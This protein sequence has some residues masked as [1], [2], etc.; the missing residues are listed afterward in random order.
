V[1]H[2]AEDRQHLSSGEVHVWTARTTDDGGTT[3]EMLQF[4]DREE[5]AR[6][7]RFVIRAD[8]M[9]FIQSHAVA[10]QILAGYS[11]IDAA[12]L[13]FAHNERGKPYLASHVSGRSLQFSVSHSGHC[14]MIAV[15]HDH[16]V[17][18][19]VELVRDMPHAIDIARRYFAQAEAGYLNSL[20]E[21]SRQDAF[22]SLWT[23]KEAMVKA[24]GGSIAESL[25]SIEFGA[26]PGRRLRLRSINENPSLVRKWSV[27]RLDPAPG[28]VGAVASVRP[29]R[30]FKMRA[31]N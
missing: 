13:V 12:T 4:L 14:C 1:R 11:G 20:P 31:W 21:T 22:F 25:R 9:C 5:R 16:P 7:T 24:L 6:A 3:A 30:S 28:Y 23:H 2:C 19:D 15:R 27:V 8:R 10:R 29:V 17:G 18:I 26:D